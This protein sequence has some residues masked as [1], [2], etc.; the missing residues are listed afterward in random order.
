M[1]TYINLP[2]LQD[3]FRGRKGTPAGAE[4]LA[5]LMTNTLSGRKVQWERSLAMRSRGKASG[6]QLRSDQGDAF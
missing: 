3:A 4:W 2:L 5:Y 1:S 6:Q